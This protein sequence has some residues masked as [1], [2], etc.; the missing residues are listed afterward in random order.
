MLRFSRI[1]IMRQAFIALTLIA[2]PVI[3]SAQ[4]AS[5]SDVS[6]KHPAFPAVE[7]L[8]KEGILQ[9]YPDG[10]F[11]PDVTVNRAEAVKIIAA[12]L[13][14]KAILDQ[15]TSSVYGD[16]QPG[17]WFKGYVE[18]A[19]QTLGILDGPPKA[20]MFYG[21]RPVNK[22]EFLK[23]LLLANKIDPVSAFSE[24]TMPLSSDVADS[25]QWYYPYMRYAIASSMTMVETDGTL[26]PGKQLTRG[27]VSLLLFRLMMYRQNRRTQALLTEAESEILNILQMLETGN[28]TQAEFSSTRALLAARGALM[29]NPNEP[30]VKGAVKITEGFGLLVR[31][32]KSG[33]SSDLQS[34]IDQAGDA[35]QLAEK[36]KGF[37]ASLEPLASQMQ[38][39]AKN[40]ADEARAMMH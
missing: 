19:R 24:I 1:V 16:V 18:A 11:R 13:L 22:A 17:S 21:E 31:A 39:I 28:S 7:F 29:S 30:L 36:A 5:F 33:L 2:L 4:D 8:K 15:Y 27:E 10:T 14:E 6:A 40:M 35:W 32:Y 38:G 25:S 12:P 20:T 9:G 26:Q 3:A 34:V 37:A 23:M